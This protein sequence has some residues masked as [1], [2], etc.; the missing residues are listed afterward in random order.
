MAKKII[1]E[2]KSERHHVAL[3]GYELSKAEALDMITLL[4]AMLAQEAPIGRS[5]GGCP[6]INVSERG[7]VVKRILLTLAR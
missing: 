5:S 7:Q 6:E 2:A 3:E 1:D 4:A